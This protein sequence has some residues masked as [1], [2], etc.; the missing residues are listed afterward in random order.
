[1][2]TKEKL[3]ALYEL[4]CA[5][6]VS[7]MEKQALVDSVLTPEIRQKIADIEAEFAEKNA[8]VYEKLAALETEVKTDV[9]SG[10]ETV[11]GDYLMAVYNKGRVSWDTKSLDGYAAAHPEVAQFKKTGDPSVSIRTL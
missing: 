9:V 2:N 1:M 7:N 3:N 4:K 11:K 8:A 5:I 10:G 6:E